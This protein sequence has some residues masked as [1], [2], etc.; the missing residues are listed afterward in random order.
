MSHAKR[1]FET[2]RETKVKTKKNVLSW[3][4][5]SFALVFP[6]Q[7]FLR[8]LSF[9]VKTEKNG[10]RESS[11][12]IQRVPQGGKS[13]I[14]SAWWSRVR[15]NR[16]LNTLQHREYLFLIASMVRYLLMWCCLF[17]FPLLYTPPQGIGR[18]ERFVER[19]NGGKE[20]ISISMRGPLLGHRERDREQE[21]RNRN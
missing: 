18:I 7:F 1:E 13:L 10:S 15:A 16:K 19:E 21:R 17:P 3:I 6:L 9:S 14:P 20:T 12:S 5:C 4:L 11:S 2:I 8:Q